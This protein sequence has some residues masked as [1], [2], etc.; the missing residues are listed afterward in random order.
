M[1]YSSSS[2]SS[3]KYAAIKDL[4]ELRRAIAAAILKGV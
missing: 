4:S 3:S 1:A 2:S